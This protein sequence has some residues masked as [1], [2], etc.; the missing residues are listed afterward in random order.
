MHGAWFTSSVPV[1]IYWLRRQGLVVEG[2]R[3]T[4]GGDSD[5]AP[6]FRRPDHDLA[7]T[8]PPQERRFSAASRRRVPH[9]EPEGPGTPPDDEPGGPGGPHA[10]GDQPD[11][12]LRLRD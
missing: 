9:P 2:M 12:H 11:G 4:T 3:Q 8:P 10:L 6:R 1:D 7:F 5:R